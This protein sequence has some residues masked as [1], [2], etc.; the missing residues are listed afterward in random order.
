MGI[1]FA[2]LANTRPYESVFF[3]LPIAIALIVWTIGRSAPEF[4]VLVRRTVIPLTVVVA[5][6]L[7]AMGYYFWRVTGSPFRIPYQVNMA[8]YHLVYFPWQKL[9]PDAEYHHAVMREFYQGPPVV[10]QYRRARLHPLLWLLAK[11]LPH[12]IFFLGP[13]LLMPVIVWLTVRPCGTLAK[14]FSSKTRFL[15]MLCCVTMIGMMLPVYIP[16]AHYAAPMTAAIYALLLQSMR[17]VRL[18]QS[19]GQPSGLFLVRAVVVICLAL[20][21]VRAAASLLHIPVP[22]TVIHTWY[23]EDVHNLDRANVL[24]QL[25]REPGQ[26]LVIVRYS[27]DHEILGEWVY[28]RADI[29]N[30][31]VV[32]ARDMGAERNAELIQYFKDRHVWLLEPDNKPPKRFAYECASSP[33]ANMVASGEE[34]RPKATN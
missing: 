14:S 21:P 4:S 30:A 28:N 8:A 25:E 10:G 20:L 17:Y 31:K 22:V 7:A 33:C 18:W 2:I 3:C 27:P 26:H 6:V 11:P 23:T 12:L 24:N 9:T 32:W 1:G 13:A 15:I 29:D 16:P 34:G 5:L 19:N